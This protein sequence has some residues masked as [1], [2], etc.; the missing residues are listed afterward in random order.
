M[1]I[2]LLHKVGSWFQDP[3]FLEI[4]WIMALLLKEVKSQIWHG[5]LVHEK[6]L[7]EFLN[8]LKTAVILVDLFLTQM[9]KICVVLIR[10][11]PACL[12]WL[13]NS[14]SVFFGCQS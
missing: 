2:G 5:A 4:N 7:L 3:R 8:T 10:S 14:L 9:G 12:S 1:L 11:L 6:I 13:S